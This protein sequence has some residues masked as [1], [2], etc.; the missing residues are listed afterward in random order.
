MGNLA[1]FKA[2]KKIFGYF[3]SNLHRDDQVQLPRIALYSREVMMG[4]YPDRYSLLLQPPLSETEGS[5]SHL[6]SG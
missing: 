6:P 1:L 2:R 5:H 4:V 3:S